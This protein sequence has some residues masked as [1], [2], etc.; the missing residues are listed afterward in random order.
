MSSKESST[1]G[2]K[3]TETNFRGFTAKEICSIIRICSKSG[4]D[5]IKLGDLRINFTPDRP[6]DQQDQSKTS[7]WKEL[8]IPQ[9]E[10]K[11]NLS[12]A[13]EK[14]DYLSQLM[15][16]DPSEYENVLIEEHLYRGHNEATGN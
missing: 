9:E 2:T 6:V 10:E 3:N 4:V 8:S 12:L 15:V 5:S 14:E 13:E 16:E 1:T 7:D 11:T